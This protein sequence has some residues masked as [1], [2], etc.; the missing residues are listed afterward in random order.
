MADKGYLVRFV[1]T[2][3][4]QCVSISGIITVILFLAWEGG[5]FLKE[6][7]LIFVREE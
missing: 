2:D 7:A 3:S 1:Y 5:H 6:N 4:S